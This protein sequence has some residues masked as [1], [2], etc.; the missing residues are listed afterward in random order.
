MTHFNLCS[1]IKQ[2]LAADSYEQDVT[3]S[4][5]PHE[6][7]PSAAVIIAKEPGCFS[8]TEVLE[9]FRFLFK[10]SLSMIPHLAE[11]QTIEKGQKALTLEGTR[12]LILSVERTLLNF[13]G[14]S[15]GVASLT[16][17]FV[18]AIKPHS[19]TLLATRKTLPGLR[20]LQLRAVEAGGGKIHRRSLADGILIKENH[21]AQEDPLVLLKR[22][23]EKASPLHRVEI[24]VQNFEVLS[25]VL[26]SSHCPEVIMLDNFSVEEVR[27]A[28]AL[29]R[30]KRPQVKIEVSG[31]I[32][33]TTI[34]NY[35]ATGVDFISVGQITHS[36]PVFNFSLDF[37]A[38]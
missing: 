30:S 28:V 14:V 36:A 18:E 12:P 5:L 26:E 15:C 16:K 21:Y 34:K 20:T 10:E 22:A 37:V 38:S 35:A 3:A 32:S 11:G 24:E 13:L 7:V 25:N 2:E 6:N 4:L 8:G 29:I 27:Q 19:A 33:L 9:S 17:S 23:V 31:G 1:L